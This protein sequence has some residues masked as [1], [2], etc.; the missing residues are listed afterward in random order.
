MRSRF[1]FFTTAVLLVLGML[2]SARPA[3]ADP[4]EPVMDSGCETY[5]FEGEIYDS[6]WD[7]RGVIQVTELSSGLYK[8]T[9]NVTEA[10]SLSAGGVLLDSTEMQ[11]QYVVLFKGG[12]E[13]IAISH[14]TGSFSFTNPTTHVLTTCTYHFALNYVEGELVHNVA[15]NEC[16]S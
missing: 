7:V 4:A 5:E 12:E 15:I 14:A 8:L 3:A 2:G 6:C 16:T 13:H 10:Y 9:S 1:T 11:S